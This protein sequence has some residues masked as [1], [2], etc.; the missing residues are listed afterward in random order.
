MNVT[1]IVTITPG[2]ARGRV[3]IPPSKSV[4]HRALICAALAS[5]G[6][7]SRLGGMPYNQ[8]IDATM[9]CL[10][11]LGVRMT[12]EREASGET[13]CVTVFG[14]GGQWTKN[15]EPL[16][17]RESGSTLRF[18]LPLCLLSDAPRTLKGSERLLA[19]PLDDYRSL[20]EGREWTSVEGGLRIGGGSVLRGQT[21]SLSGKSSSQFITGLLFVLPLLGEDSVIELPSAPESK[22]YIDMTIAV[23]AR[24]GVVATWQ[25]DTHL[26]VKGGQTYRAADMTA[27]GDASGAAFF[28]ALDAL[29]S[30]GEP[31]EIV[32]AGSDDVR[33]GDAVCPSLLAQ[34][35]AAS[36]DRL[37]VISLADCPDL[38][39]ILF[40][41]AA[42]LHGAIFTHTDRLR[43]K[44]SDRISTMVQELEK[45]GARFE[46]IDGVD[47][48]RV[49][50]LPPE[51]GLHTPTGV[52]RGH[53]DHRVVMSLAVLSACMSD[54]TPIRID[55]AHAVTKSFPDFFDR[56]RK[57]GVVC[58]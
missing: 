1:D 45:F 4:A 44:E 57:L 3:V 25:D 47:G 48:G 40:T 19:R 34:I 33:Q 58:E 27:D 50:V 54:P 14:C 36:P 17:C 13:R 43:L 26:I 15:D 29:K 46:V 21:F 35:A 16:S 7:V 56:L 41:A 9:D 24:F 2:V 55:D 52:L 32:C 11:A 12:D 6:C 5:R 20:F 30:G 8:D 23:Q 51:G 37:P 53:N 10:R 42:A 39:P 22:S 18:L 31:L 28:Y 49:T 38:G